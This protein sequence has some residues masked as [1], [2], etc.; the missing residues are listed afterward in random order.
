MELWERR[1]ESKGSGLSLS[2]DLMF[3]EVII[4]VIRFNIKTDKYNIYDLIL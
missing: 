1:V 3:Q 2:C 4:N